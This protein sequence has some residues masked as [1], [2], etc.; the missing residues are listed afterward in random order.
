MGLFNK[1]VFLIVILFVR[2]VPVMRREEECFF[3]LVIFFR[4]GIRVHLLVLLLR[5]FSDGNMK[6]NHVRIGS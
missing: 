6:M 2:V 1:R 5:L 3:L 4:G